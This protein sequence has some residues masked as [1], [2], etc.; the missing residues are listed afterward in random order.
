LARLLRFDLE[1]RAPLFRAPQPRALPRPI[2]GNVFPQVGSFDT[3]GRSGEETKVAAELRKIWAAP[4]LRVSVTAVRVPV[5]RGHSLAAWLRFSKPITPGRARGLL[6]RS[7]NLDLLQ[8]PDY[9]TPLDTAGRLPVRAGRLRQGVDK[10][11]LAMWV[12]SDNLLKG[13]ALNSVQ[14]AEYILGKGWL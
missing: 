7:L 14:I 1:G 6:G 4:A 2:A 3:Q 12:V 11:E 9:P 5:V 13:A 10:R 8:D